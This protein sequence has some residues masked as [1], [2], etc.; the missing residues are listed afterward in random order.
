MRIQS[1]CL[2]ITFILLSPCASAQWVQTNGPYGGEIACLAVSGTNI[3]AGN[4]SGVFRSPERWGLRPL[5]RLRVFTPDHVRALRAALRTWRGSRRERTV[6]TK[7][8]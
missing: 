6:R 4:L 1:I 5:P 2:A 3:F 8:R 7:C